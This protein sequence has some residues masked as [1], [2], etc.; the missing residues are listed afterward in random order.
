MKALQVA[1]YDKDLPKA[2]D[3]LHVVTK[4]V[5]ALK[6]GEVLVRVEAC[7]CNPS[8]LLF[9]QGLYG[10][11]KSLPAVPGW[12]GAGTVVATGG[13]LLGWW[14]KGK[15]VAFAIQSD[16]DGT[17]AQY[18]VADAKFCVP[19]NENIPIEQAASLIINPL[20]AIAMMQLARNHK[21]I[22][23]NAAASQVGRMIISL[24]ARAKKP[25]INIVR[26]PEQVELLMSLG[27]KNILHSEDPQFLTNLK[28][29]SAQLNATCAFE[30][31]AGGMTGTLLSALPRD[32]VVHVYG[33]LSGQP[34]G[35][36]SPLSLIFEEKRVEGFWLTKWIEE[37]GTI[38]MLKIFKEVQNLI[39]QGLINTE[40]SQA[41]SLDSAPAAI[42]AYTREMS[43]GKVIIKP[44]LS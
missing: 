36:I 41:V 33:G 18:S 25:L 26:R 16:R 6:A 12:E 29:L 37:Q 34:C 24:A 42:K 43:R 23:Q 44:Q 20:S 30:A 35:G 40:I 10:V 17:W 14:L 9:L 1:S 31:I 3:Q 27:A 11:T 19:L 7:P 5:P 21:A 28:N 2:L 13:G 38:G 4:N 39:S 15:R 22:V 8:D 32:S